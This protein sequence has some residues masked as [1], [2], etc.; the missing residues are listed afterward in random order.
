VVFN[1]EKMRQQAAALDDE[2][3]Q[4]R[5][6]RQSRD[7]AVTAVVSGRG[8]LL[9]LKISNQVMRGVHPHVV[10]ADVVE[11]VTAARRHAAA[12][13]RPKARAV[14]DKDQVWEPEHVP[15]TPG[16]LGGPPTSADLD[17]DAAPPA[18]PPAAARPSAR[19]DAEEEDFAEI[20]FLTDEGYEDDDREP[21]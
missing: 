21:R 19:D 5:F 14:F 2:L 1:A 4:V 6:T 15:A 16:F 7:G 20:D 18:A 8:Q 10:G 13:A 17:A 11:A 3:G 9:D 12:V